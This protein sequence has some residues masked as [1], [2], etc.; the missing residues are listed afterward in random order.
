[1]VSA[2]APAARCT[3]CLVDRAAFERPGIQLRNQARREIDMKTRIFGSCTILVLGLAAMH[4]A[5]SAQE[6]PGIEGVWFADVTPVNCQT[7]NPVGLSFRALYMFGHDGSMTTEAAFLI[8]TPLRSS[9]LGAW[10]HDQARM[11]HSTF[12]F[13]RYN[14]DGSLLGTR[15]VASTIQLNDDQFTTLDKI[16]EYNPTGVVVFTGCAVSTAKRAQ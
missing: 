11:F 15:E 14:P 4:T 6:T 10:L 7:L 5:A 13:F 9:G 2:P 3:R 12:W 8:P 16:T 1:M